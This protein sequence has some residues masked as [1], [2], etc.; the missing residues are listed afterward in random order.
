M[1]CSSASDLEDALI[2]RLEN[3][4]DVCI[5]L[6][7]T[8]APSACGM[9]LVELLRTAVP[10]AYAPAAQNRLSTLDDGLSQVRCFRQGAR[11]SAGQVGRRLDIPRAEGMLAAGVPP[12]GAKLDQI[13]ARFLAARDLCVRAPHV[14]VCLCVSVCLCSWSLTL[15]LF[16]YSVHP[17]L[18]HA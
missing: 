2:V 17:A 7:A 4:R 18:P 16:A 14:C 8:L 12:G 11:V 1:P 5:L 13:H 15:S 6:R 3:G 10:A 9:R